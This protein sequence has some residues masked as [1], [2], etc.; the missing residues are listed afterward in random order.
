MQN[1][2]SS[3]GTVQYEYHFIR[4]L[5]SSRR[6]ETPVKH[7]WFP[8]VRFSFKMSV[9]KVVRRYGRVKDR[10]AN[11]AEVAAE[12]PKRKEIS[13]STSPRRR[14]TVQYASPPPVRKKK[15]KA[16]GKEDKWEKKKC[17]QK[18]RFFLPRAR[19]RE[20]SAHVARPTD[21][22]ERRGVR[23]QEKSG[24]AGMR[25]GRQVRFFSTRRSLFSTRPS[26]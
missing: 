6:K 14:R 23:Y 22:R 19:P 11:R 18:P 9:D 21:E 8:G 10:A 1:I 15:R 16:K 26:A 5:T 25:G 4:G 17:R 3:T 2:S 7:S 24:H 20:F 12:S 13:G